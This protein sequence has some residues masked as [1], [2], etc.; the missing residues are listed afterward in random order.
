MRDCV[1]LSCYSPLKTSS[2]GNIY[3]SSVEIMFD[4]SEPDEPNSMLK[5]MK[6][7]QLTPTDLEFI[8]KMKAEKHIKRLQVI[9]SLAAAASLQSCS[10][11]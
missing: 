5:G 3:I 2:L 8:E 7:Y 9:F 10:P 4:F 1:L 6:G 11:V